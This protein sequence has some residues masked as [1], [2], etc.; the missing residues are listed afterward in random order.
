MRERE[1][2]REGERQKE[3]ERDGDREADVEN[4]RQQAMEECIQGLSM[5]S[6]RVFGRLQ[7][8]MRC[9][10]LSY[11]KSQVFSYSLRFLDFAE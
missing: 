1:T 11:A 4:R 8:R 6:V 7:A 2:E 5:S 9:S 3:R 10:R